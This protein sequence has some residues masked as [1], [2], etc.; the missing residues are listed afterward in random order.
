MRAL[1]RH[2]ASHM[3]VPP[4][5]RHARANPC[6]GGSH[7]KK[8]QHHART[9]RAARPSR[10]CRCL[11][12]S[13]RAA[14]HSPELRGR[15]LTPDSSSAQPA[16]GRG[17]AEILS[18][19]WRPPQRDCIKHGAPPRHAELY[20]IKK[21]GPPGANERPFVRRFRG[22]SLPSGGPSAPGRRKIMGD[23][24]K[25]PGGAAPLPSGDPCSF[26]TRVP[27]GAG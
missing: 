12:E 3:K 16:G 5:C 21:R 20:N 10:A 26:L 17:C 22:F 2:V 15:R 18:A 8:L 11:I 4:W 23:T 19:G 9:P 1:V 7:L 27:G 24:P 14:R 13:R 6:D 25:P